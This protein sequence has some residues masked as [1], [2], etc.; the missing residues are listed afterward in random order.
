[1]RRL[2]CAD[3]D[4]IPI[5]TSL[6]V[7]DLDESLRKCGGLRGNFN[8]SQSSDGI[9]LNFVGMITAISSWA[10][11]LSNWSLGATFK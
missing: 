7:R 5:E 2:G 11:N 10:L 6:L 4:A 1:M 3:L 9:A 8:C